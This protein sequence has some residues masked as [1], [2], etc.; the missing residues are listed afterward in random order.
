MAMVHIKSGQAFGSTTL[1]PPGSRRNSDLSKSEILFSLCA[2]TL[3]ATSSWRDRPDSINPVPNLR[4]S[5]LRPR[6]PR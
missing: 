5:I 6:T 1:V 2:L 3:S 4:N